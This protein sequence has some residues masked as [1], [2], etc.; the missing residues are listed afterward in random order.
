MRRV[1]TVLADVWVGLAASALFFYPLVAA[2]D[3]QIVLLDWEPAHT[4]ELVVAFALFASVAA[5]LAHVSRRSQARVWAVVVPMLAV[6]P[7]ASFAL[8][9]LRRLAVKEILAPLAAYPAV[10]VGLALAAAAALGGAALRAGS[11]LRLTRL[12]ILALSPVTVIVLLAIGRLAVYQPAPFWPAD[13]NAVANQGKG[14]HVLVLLFD[15]LSYA[16]LYDGRAIRP[17]Y[18]ALRSFGAAA[19][20]HHAA[21]APGSESLVSIPGYLSG[22]RYADTDATGDAFEEVFPDGHR[23]RLDLNTPENLF[24]LARTAGLRTEYYGW[25]FPACRM[26]PGLLDRCLDCSLYNASGVRPAFSPMDAVRTNLILWPHQ[27][28]AGLLKNPPFA[29]H[30]RLAAARLEALAAE[31]FEPGVGTLRF[32]H[33]S[34]PH[35]PFVFDRDGFN[36]PFDPVAESLG[37]YRRQLEY[38]D[39]VFGRILAST[40][41]R[42]TDPG[43]S[44]VVLSDHEYRAVAPREG[45]SH[46]PVLVRTPAVRE[47]RDVTEAERAEEILRKV[48]DQAVGAASTASPETR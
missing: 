39:R 19:V 35:V 42:Q 43:T 2:A 46:V 32:V 14:A 37:A 1:G 17:A 7:I 18:P 28:P 44:I 26:L 3:S 23:T 36:P 29:D 25:Y 15:E 22:R 30:Q 20:H 4:A 41:A 34:I 11:A 6:I 24:R 12:A 13:S 45:W 40:D 5:L 47:R 33:F 16:Q 27:F 21:T 31:P 48:V 10:R 9:M 38:V 8:A